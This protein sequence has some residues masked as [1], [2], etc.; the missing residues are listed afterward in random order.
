QQTN[1]HEEAETILQSLLT[2]EY[3][4]R[5]PPTPRALERIAQLRSMRGDEA[6]AYEALQQA[7]ELGWADYYEAIND[8]RWGNTLSKPRFVRLLER[9]QADLAQQREEVERRE[10]GAE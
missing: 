2:N 9:V 4:V 5:I 1:R 10:A 8:P 3:L 7:V 6:G